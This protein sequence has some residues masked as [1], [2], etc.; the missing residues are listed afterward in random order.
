MASQTSA[1]GFQGYT[2]FGKKI[3]TSFFQRQI[4]FGGS[5]FLPKTLTALP[6]HPFNRLSFFFFVLFSFFF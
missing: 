4:V 1:K 5:I 3:S 2:S 6:R